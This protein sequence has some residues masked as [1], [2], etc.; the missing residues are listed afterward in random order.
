MHFLPTD[1]E[2]YEDATELPLITKENGLLKKET[3][4][5]HTRAVQHVTFLNCDHPS[6]SESTADPNEN[7][8]VRNFL[9]LFVL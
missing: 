2:G 7:S 1:D 5:D 3:K 9:L 4:S 8:V 6:S